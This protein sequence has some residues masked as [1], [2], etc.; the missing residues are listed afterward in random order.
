MYDSEIILRCCAG[1]MP[2]GKE[3]KILFIQRLIDQ[4]IMQNGMGKILDLLTET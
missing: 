4:L 1:K 3:Y 2:I